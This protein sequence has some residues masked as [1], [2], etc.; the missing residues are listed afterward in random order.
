MNA[1]LALLAEDYT[2]DKG[3][4]FIEIILIG[5]VVVGILLIIFSIWVSK[6]DSP[7]AVKQREANAELRASQQYFDDDDDDDRNYQLEDEMLQYYRNKNFDRRT[8]R[9]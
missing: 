5:S 2:D 9:D 3:L 8:G 6:S 7:W 1:L 4:D